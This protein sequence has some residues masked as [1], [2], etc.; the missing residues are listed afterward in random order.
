M[1]SP[2]FAQLSEHVYYLPGA[3]N[4]AVVVNGGEAVLVDTGG[5]KDY[6][7]A[8]RKVCEALTVTPVAILNT[9]SHADHYG[10]NDYLLRQFDVPVYAPA[11][12]AGILQNPYLE[13]VYLFNGAKPL[14]ELMSKWLL[15]KPSKV[16][17]VSEPGRLELV[18]L[19][20]D[21]LDT[22][23]HAHRHLSVKVGDVLI[24]ADAV[25]GAAVLD[26]YPLPFGQD[27][28]GQM[29]S[30]QSLTEVEARVL[31]PGHGEP[32][33]HI[34]DLVA[35][36]L[37][38]F[39]RAADAVEAACLGVSTEEVLTKVCKNLDIEMINLP[40]FFL[41]RCVVTGYLSYLREM[42]RVELALRDNELKW[43]RTGT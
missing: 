8:L 13:P 25:F 1:P 16:D 9:H 35:H 4:C 42:G 20:F 30:A 23:G 15:A 43:E 12:E 2:L 5:D 17:V 3:V 11:F 33:E 18:G 27:I 36:N 14:P 31:L 37:E 32:T 28:G 7:R 10:G 6:G 34:G 29:K 40:R 26:K 24:A 19:E 38:A 41:N 22:S 21:I 39:K